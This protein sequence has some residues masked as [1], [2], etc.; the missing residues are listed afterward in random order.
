MKKRPLSITVFNI[1]IILWI[2][3][4]F[5]QLVFSGIHWNLLTSLEAEFFELSK[6]YNLQAFDPNLE[7]TAS[8]YALFTSWV[9]AS[10]AMFSLTCVGVW[11]KYNWARY[12]LLLHLINYFG[13]EGFYSDEVSIELQS[14][15]VL[16]MLTEFLTGVFFC[17]AI[18]ALSE[19]KVGNDQLV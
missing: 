1:S 12:A 13:M 5:L 10:L 15:F 2:F 7:F 14:I 9:I 11:K 4:F 3:L 6:K 17:S 18:W 8:E 16:R 19:G